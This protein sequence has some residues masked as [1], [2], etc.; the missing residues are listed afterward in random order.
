MET[1]VSEMLR[2]RP[3]D[4]LSAFKGFPAFCA[5]PLRKRSAGVQVLRLKLII[6]TSLPQPALFMRCLGEK[7][8]EGLAF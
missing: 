7:D 5:V 3:S 4:L 6:H 2:R 1:G 8:F